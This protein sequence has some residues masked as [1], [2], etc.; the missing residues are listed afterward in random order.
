MYLH[1]ITIFFFISSCVKKYCSTLHIR[2]ILL[3]PTTQTYRMTLVTH[4]RLPLAFGK[5]FLL[6]G[7]TTYR[8][9][10]VLP[11]SLC[12]NNNSN[13]NRCGISTMR[14]PFVMA[15]TAPRSPSS[16]LGTTTVQQQQQQRREYF[17]ESD[18][19][20]SWTS[21]SSDTTTSQ[22]QKNKVVAA[23]P[24]SKAFV[25]NIEDSAVIDLFFK[26]A[27]ETTDH[28]QP[29]LNLEGVHRLLE[30][31]G[32]CHDDETVGRLFADADVDKSG[33]VDLEE[34]LVAA[35]STVVSVS[36]DD[37]LSQYANF[38]AS[39]RCIYVCIYVYIYIYIRCPFT[40]ASSNQ[41]FFSFFCFRTNFWAAL[42]QELF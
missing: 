41:Q 1:Y 16:G 19:K 21:R 24:G 11:V 15:A 25:S 8:N 28:G 31:I 26:Y 20:T 29:S 2:K 10:N 39:P 14:Y 18:D 9:Y 6:S 37:C 33:C 27:S 7:T 40:K 13:S 34:F 36:D 30:G 12:T 22:Q 38:N 35:V 3:T 4:R 42:P 23:K 32:E 17:G 5:R